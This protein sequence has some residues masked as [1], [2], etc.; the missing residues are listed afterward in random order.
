[1]E[2]T[3]AEQIEQFK[4]GLTSKATGKEGFPINYRDIRNMLMSIPD[5]GKIVPKFIKIYRNEGE[6]WSYI[7][8]E[9]DHYDERRSFLSE[10]LNPIIDYFEGLESSP[11]SQLEVDYEKLERIGSG[12]F[13]EVFTFKNTLLDHVFAVK[14]LDPSFQVDSDKDLIRFFQEAKMLFELNHPNIIRIYDVGISNR[15]PFIRMEY[16]EGKNLNEV[17]KEYGILDCYKCINLIREVASAM[18]HAHEY[19]VHR[20]IKPSNIMVAYP[21]KFKIIDF[22]LGIYKERQLESRI[23]SL[24]HG[25]GGSIYT[26][27]E[28]HIDPHLIDKRSDIY[29]VGAVWYELLVGRAPSGINI[30]KYLEGVNGISEKYIDILM[31]CLEDIENRY[32]SFSELLNQIQVLE[33]ELV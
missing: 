29:S 22:G 3:K 19:L 2:L 13:G 11:I 28:L 6:F 7:K 17:L 14:F 20:D 5:L 27:P 15:K 9:F 8:N 12:G 30:R 21:N 16:F 31:K 18:E 23:T 1:M 25:I 24:A 26:A 32:N 10:K 4:M 33:N